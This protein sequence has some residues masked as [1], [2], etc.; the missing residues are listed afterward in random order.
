MRNFL[1]R[2]A[3]G[4]IPRKIDRQNFRNKYLKQ[5]V[6]DFNTIV[7]AEISSEEDFKID[8]NG[9]VFVLIKEDGTRVYNPKI[10]GLR[11]NFQGKDN[12][13]IIESPQR[14]YFNS[15]IN[16]IGQ[17]ANVYIK[18]NT[19][20]SF[21]ISNLN[22]RIGSNNKLVVGEN[23]TCN[24][25][26]ISLDVEKNVSINI[27]TDVMFSYG[28]QMRTSDNHAILSK[29][30]NGKWG[31]TNFAKDITIGNH[32]WIAQNVFIAKGS[33]I[34]DNSVVRACSF[35][36]KAFNENNVIIAGNPARIVKRNSNWDRT[37]PHLY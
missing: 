32:V 18:K 11:V 13:V 28:I 2:L 16:F 26:N 24:G 36:N 12:T 37:A 8:E 10:E 29:N 9:N 23:F 14:P 4:F 7:E 17:K 21:T 1:V 25:A 31:A 27:G 33:K 3:T 19:M 30:Q 22:I 15:N 35:V 20:N 34:P 6:E 5:N